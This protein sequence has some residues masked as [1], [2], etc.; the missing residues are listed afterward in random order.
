MIYKA[1]LTEQARQDLR[2]IYEYIAFSLLEPEIAKKLKNRIVNRLQS[3]E[4][5]PARFPLYAEKPWESRGLRVI[6]IGNY[7]GFYLV[8]EDTVQ[9]IRI[10]YGGRDIGNILNESLTAE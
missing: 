10:L 5:M 6:N 1:K 8:G 2:G 7:S 9:V 3:L 4:E